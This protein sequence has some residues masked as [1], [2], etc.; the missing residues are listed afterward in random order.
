MKLVLVSSDN[1]VLDETEFTRKEWDLIIENPNG[2]Q[3]LLATLSAG[4]AE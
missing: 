4:D 2:C 1:T 3:L